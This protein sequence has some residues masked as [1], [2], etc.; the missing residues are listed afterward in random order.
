MIAKSVCKS[1]QR[2]FWH[3]DTDV[4]GICLAK[5]KIQPQFTF[6]NPILLCSTEERKKFPKLETEILVKFIFLSTIYFSRG[7]SKSKRQNKN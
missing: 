6:Q 5:A 7:K 1:L 4:V 2:K 3:F